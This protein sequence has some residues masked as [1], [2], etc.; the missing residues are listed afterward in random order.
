MNRIIT[1]GPI[2][3]WYAFVYD[4]VQKILRFHVRK[5]VIR[6]AEADLGL[7]PDFVRRFRSSLSIPDDISF[8][9]SF[10][11]GFGFGGVIKYVAESEDFQI[12]EAP[13]PKVT[14]ITGTCSTCSGTGENDGM[15]CF[16]CDGGVTYE[17]RWQEADALGASLA[18]F[19]DLL[20]FEPENNEIQPS[21]NQP[22]TLQTCME[23]QSGGASLNG[24]FSPGFANMLPS[25][26]RGMIKSDVSKM[27]FEL[28]VHMMRT[29][30]ESYVGLDL[31]RCS[32]CDNRGG[33][34]ITCPGDAS[35]L[36]PNEWHSIGV[37]GRGYDF[38]SHNVDHIGQQ[39][40]LL[41]ALGYLQGEWA[42]IIGIHL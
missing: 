37:P 29:G 33:L 15:N 4:P 9:R 12:F 25:I 8:S 38:S 3:A 28:W 13:F 19:F 18:L 34:I 17:L 11:S 39:A 40:V 14:H 32:V 5:D 42:K 31:H 2:P 24:S 41:A 27:M 16:S 35:G 36:N 10:Q 6:S 22:L 30:K 7:G 26:M 20:A 23:K 21:F 1:E